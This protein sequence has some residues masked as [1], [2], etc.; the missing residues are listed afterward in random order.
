M[1]SVRGTCRDVI[2]WPGHSRLGYSARMPERLCIAVAAALLVVPALGTAQT[3]PVKGEAILKHPLGVLATKTVDAIAAGRFDEVMALRTK[4]DLDDW[5]SASA[6]DRKDFAGRLKERAPAPA[7][8]ADLVRKAG[9]LTVEGDTAT[10]NLITMEP[11]ASRN[12]RGSST[13]VAIPLALD[14]AQW[15]VAQ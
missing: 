10:L 1:A 12:G 13:T 9:E 4:S 11:A 2:R 15:K 14:N 8:F 6:A 3:A 7:A 5:K